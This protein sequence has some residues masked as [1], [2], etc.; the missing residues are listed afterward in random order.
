M[1]TKDEERNPDS[2]LTPKIAVKKINTKGRVKK[3]ILRTFL[4]LPGDGGLRPA[5]GQTE[6]VDVLAFIHK[7]V[8]GDVDDSGRY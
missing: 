8:R 1:K 4:V 6:E 3:I 2:A 7:H 5:H